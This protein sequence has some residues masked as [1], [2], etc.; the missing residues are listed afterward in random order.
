VLH[1]LHDI[2]GHRKIAARWVPHEITEVQQWHLYGIAQDML[3]RYQR[4]GDDFLGRIITTDETWARSYE[5]QLKRQSSEWKHP[6]SPRPKKV[7]PAQGGVKVMFIVAYD[8]HGVILYH[9][10]PKRHRVN[11]AYYCNFLKHH[12]RPALRRKRRHLMATNPSSLMTMRGVTLL[13][14]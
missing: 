4:E 12:L 3:N 8:I 11:A 14:L 9:A 10:A 7:R 6:G 5:P 2:L 1:I 13:T